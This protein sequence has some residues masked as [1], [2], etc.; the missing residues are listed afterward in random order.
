MNCAIAILYGV[1][2]STLLAV[3]L[4]FLRGGLYARSAA[5]ISA[6]FWAARRLRLRLGA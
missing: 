5:A 3:A 6:Y 2:S 4:S 1:S